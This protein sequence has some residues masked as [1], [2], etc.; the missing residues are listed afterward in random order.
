MADNL[1]H[2]YRFD[3]A[4]ALYQEIAASADDPGIVMEANRRSV[5]CENGKNMLRYADNPSV[6]GKGEV[7]SDYFFN[8]YFFDF[9]GQWALVPPSWKFSQETEENNPY[10]SP[11]FVPRQDA[12]Q[13]FYSMLSPDGETGYD[14]YVIKKI[15]D[16]QWG[17][18]ERLND[19]VNSPFDELFPYSPDGKTLYFAS[20]GHFG[21]GGFDLYKC[22]FNET[23]QTWGAPENLGFPYSSPFDDLLYVPDKEKTSAYFASTREQKDGLITIYQVAL[24]ANPIKQSLNDLSLIQQIAALSINGG[25]PAEENK[26]GDPAATSETAAFL[27]LAEKI[28]DYHKKETDTQTELTALRRQYERSSSLDEQNSL[29]KKILDYEKQLILLQ[30]DIQETADELHKVREDLSKKGIPVPSVNGLSDSKPTQVTTAQRRVPFSL[31]E[32]EL[33]DIDYLQVLPPEGP[34][35]K[36]NLSFH[37]AEISEIYF[38]YPTPRGL[39]YHIQIGLFS[40]KVDAKLLRGISPIFVEKT[41]ANKWIYSAGMFSSYADATKAL[42]EVK[43]RNFKDAVI[44]ARLNGGRIGIK[45][46]RVE[47][48]NSTKTNESKFYQVILGT[49]EGGLPPALLAAVK[50]MSSKEVAKS[51]NT[52]VVGGFSS[53]DEAERLKVVLHEKGFTVVQVEA[54]TR[55]ESSN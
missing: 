10:V 17:A 44:T 47:E 53:E 48:A 5:L 39:I 22:T 11:V 49:Y 6:L 51:G 19:A 7:A 1:R 23:T 55:K 14:I 33:L 36:I 43:K 38:D 30:S 54:I 41:P 26:M 46:A 2:S 37:I 40:N 27:Q 24:V 28:N 31:Q 25:G 13:L 29:S 21:M 18:P 32:T 34:E 3:E 8:H 12:K 52:Y 45:E 50:E 35:P 15:D 20:N 9:G 42:V 4:I 16:S